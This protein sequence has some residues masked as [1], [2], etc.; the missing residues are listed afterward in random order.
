[1]GFYE[2][3]ISN[4]EDPT[5]KVIGKGWYQT[6]DNLYNEMIEI[7]NDQ[8]FPI[9][10]LKK[11]HITKIINNRIDSVTKNYVDYIQI[12]HINGRRVQDENGDLSFYSNEEWESRERKKR[13]RP[14]KTSKKYMSS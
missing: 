7:I 13:G 2:Y 11:S 6:Q 10:N 12:T 1:M 3:V 5:I 14:T 8:E 4:P 9:K